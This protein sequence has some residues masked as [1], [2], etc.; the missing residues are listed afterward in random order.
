MR[1]WFYI[2]IFCMVLVVSGFVVGT[3]DKRIESVY[4]DMWLSKLESLSK[5]RDFLQLKDPFWGDAIKRDYSEL[6]QN[7]KLSQVVLKGVDLNLKRKNILFEVS[8]INAHSE[9]SYELSELKKAVR[10]GIFND[11]WRV[12]KGVKIKKIGRNFQP[13]D[14]VNLVTFLVV[15]WSPES[16]EFHEQSVTYYLNPITHELK[17][18]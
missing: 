11:I 2:S 18:E 15:S 7:I 13:F 16:S 1:G 12:V 17:F 8:I 9:N 14:K 3:L 10:E 4:T 5:N 6:G